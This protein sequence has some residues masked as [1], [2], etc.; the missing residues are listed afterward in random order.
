MRILATSTQETTRMKCSK[1]DVQGKAS[2]IATLRFEDQ[3]L[4]SFAGLVVF[5][6]FFKQLGLKD[7]LRGCFAHLAT[8]AVYSHHV[9]MLL[10]V[11]HL[12]LGYRELRDLRYY[13][14]D[15][16]VKRLLG[17][18]RLPEVSTVSR[19]LAQADQRS[20]VR[21]Q[22]E[23]RD[24]VL[25]RMEKLALPRVTVDFDG[26]VLS[27]CRR[28]EGTAVGFN[29]KKKGQ[30]SYYPLFAT[31][32]QTGQVL[33]VLHRPGNVHDCNGAAKFISACV[34]P[35][36]QRLPRAV[37]ET[38]V[39]SAF[40][41]E[42]A[43]DE[44]ADRGVEFTASVPFERFGELKA[45]IEQRQRWRSIDD[46]LSY[47]EADW[48]P[49]RWSRSYRFLFIRKRVRQQYKQP[50]QLDLFIPYEYGYEFKVIVTN[51][52]LK[53]KHVILFH[54]GR[55]SQEGIF[56]ELKTHCQMGHVPVT[57]RVGNQLYLYAAVLAHNLT[58]EL[59]MQTEPPQRVTTA[60]RA[61]LWPFQQLNTLR[62]N[63]IQRAG[64]L[65]R[66]QGKLVLSMAANPTVE[67]ALRQVLDA[68][69]QPA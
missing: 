57:P 63:L 45:M 29:K 37:L 24:L 23:N 4:T 39:D 50:L 38:R 62:R 17:L 56:G 53:A 43:I 42:A 6:R 33:D 40:F 8:S 11:V 52:R 55:G 21:V 10:L 22:A 47:F 35:L 69:E 28:A 32:A 68:L 16:M 1:S 12:L 51:K 25:A 59:Q 3:T 19:R 48:K 27:T 64:R 31:V 30:R 18:K 44:L 67:R 14:D 26:S 41:S 60:K 7:R 34:E 58:R 20:V 2:P 61:A 65:I 66:P 36:R 13:Q 5:Q 49:K 15:E 46:E 54:E 9:V